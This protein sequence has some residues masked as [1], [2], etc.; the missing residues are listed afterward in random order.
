MPSIPGRYRVIPATAAE[1]ESLAALGVNLARRSIAICKSNEL[2]NSLDGHGLAGATL[3][4]AMECFEG[5][6]HAGGHGRRPLRF[7]DA[8]GGRASDDRPPPGIGALLAEDR[9]AARRLGRGAGVLTTVKETEWRCT[10]RVTYRSCLYLLAPTG[11]DHMRQTGNRNGLRGQVGLCHFL[12][13]DDGQSL[14][15]LKA[16]TGWEV[17]TGEMV[18]TALG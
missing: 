3:A 6:L 15:I 7:R 9:S 11:G 14:Q 13:Y 8:D 10:T 17:T 12:A 1:Y 16:V 18:T 2:C 4:W 5:P